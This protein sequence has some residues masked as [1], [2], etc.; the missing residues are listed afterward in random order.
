M[1]SLLVIDD[2]PLILDTIRLAFPEYEV[3][4]CSKCSERHRRI[5]AGDSRCGAV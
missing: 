4:V 2:E 1:T 5:P 3:T